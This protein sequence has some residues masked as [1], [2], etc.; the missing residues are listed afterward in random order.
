MGWGR[1]REETASLLNQTPLFYPGP[2]ISNHYVG[3]ECNKKI[4]GILGLPYM[5]QRILLIKHHPIM[6]SP[7]HLFLQSQCM[8]FVTDDKKILAAF[9]SFPS[10]AATIQLAAFHTPTIMY[11]VYYIGIYMHTLMLQTYNNFLILPLLT[12]LNSIEL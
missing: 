12:H 11:V 4:L 3:F 5:L 10:I 9:L 6:K 7:S 2:Y 8:V 1:E